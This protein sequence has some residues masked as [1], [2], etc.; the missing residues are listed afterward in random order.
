MKRTNRGFSIYSEI[1][2]ANK[3]TVRIQESSHA[4]GPLVWIFCNDANG[5]SAAAGSLKPPLASR[6]GAIREL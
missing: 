2:D 1:K 5:D 3:Q 6:K 4:D